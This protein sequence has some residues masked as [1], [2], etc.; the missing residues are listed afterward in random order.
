MAVSAKAN[1]LGRNAGD[2]QL[3]KIPSNP[4]QASLNEFVLTSETNRSIFKQHNRK[5]SQAVD[6]NNKS[7]KIVDQGSAA[8]S[9]RAG[10]S[11]ARDR[12]TSSNN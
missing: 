10:K 2:T 7:L 8:S 12:D 5:G 6:K 1:A 11:R 3:T 4:S 9:S